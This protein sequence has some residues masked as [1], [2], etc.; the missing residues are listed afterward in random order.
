MS[1]CHYLVFGE[2]QETLKKAEK[3][4]CMFYKEN[5]VHVAK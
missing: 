4:M 3:T 5:Y 1:C 2:A